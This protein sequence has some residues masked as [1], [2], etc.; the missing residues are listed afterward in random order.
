MACQ[1]KIDNNSLQGGLNIPK[2]QLCVK[3]DL[4]QCVTLNDAKIPPFEKGGKGGIFSES[5][6]QKSPPPPFHKG[7]A[8][9]HRR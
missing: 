8:K 7:G 1:E 2:R 4:A 3:K 9:N 6:G 5:L